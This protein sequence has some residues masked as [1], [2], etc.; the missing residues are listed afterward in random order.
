MS[1]A[2]DSTRPPR[3]LLVTAHPDDEAFFAVTLYRL[4]RERRVLIDVLVVTSGE[5]G[6]RYAALAEP[7][8]G[9][10]LTDPEVAR[11][12]LPAIR[13]AELAEALRV[14]G[15][16]EHLVLGEPDAG[17]S[18]DPGPFVDGSAWDRERVV[19]AIAGRLDI[20]YELM[21]VMLP[22]PETH[23]HH[24]ASALLALE[25][26]E[27]ADPALRPAVL[28]GVPRRRGEPVAYA[29]LPGWPSAQ[30]RAELPMVVVDRR[31]P[32]AGS[33]AV[34]Y[35]VVA[36]WVIAAH[37]SQGLMQTRMGAYDAE[38]YWSLACNGTEHE[39]RALALL[40]PLSAASP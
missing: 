11:E 17:F 6:Y 18:L 10:R 29:G 21:L 4:A 33:G 15:A 1:D 23:A 13:R 36:D 19:A 35:G 22:V 34:P 31:A 39:A 38:L 20:G 25:A 12:R 26:L 37:K 28:G 24:K 9:A 5:G 40:G 30:P 16:R 27:R 3:V 32:V 14:L 2:A 7:I 8:Y